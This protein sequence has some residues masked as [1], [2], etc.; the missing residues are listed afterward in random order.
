[1]CKGVQ[2]PE[3][4]PHADWRLQHVEQLKSLFSTEGVTSTDMEGTKLHYSAG[5]KPLL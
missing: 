2:L 4:L 1:M 3:T 5:S